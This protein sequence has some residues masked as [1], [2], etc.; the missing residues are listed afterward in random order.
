MTDEISLSPE[1]ASNLSECAVGATEPLTIMVKVT[2]NDEQGFKA[3]VVEAEKGEGYEE[4]VV[5]EEPVA[6][7][8]PATE[9]KPEVDTGPKGNPALVV[10]L[11]GKP[12][13]K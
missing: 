8:E 11:G 6:E 2:Q 7:E 9:K 4:E 5:E 1:M 13:K 3:E 10:V 12:P